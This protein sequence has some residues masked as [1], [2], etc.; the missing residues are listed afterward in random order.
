MYLATQCTDAPWPKS[1]SK[2]REDNRRV[3]AKAPFETWANA[4]FNGPCSF[5]P[6]KAA[7]PV[8]VN[9]KKV[10]KILM[11][12]ET[13]DAATPFA[14]S[15]KVRKLFPR[16]SLIEG[17]GGTT[18]AGSL[19]GVACTDDA[20]G[21]YLTNG[22]VPKR[23]SGN[24]SDLTCPPVPQPDPTASTARSKSLAR[25]VPAAMAQLRKELIAAQLHR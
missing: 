14:G 12:G 25:P 16:A 8:K 23:R 3:Y 24:R 2:V 6:A 11:I 18:H 9:G 15:L 13:L 20:I 19:S 5:W 17:V 22:A 7:Q 4:W 10:P 1:W 21:R